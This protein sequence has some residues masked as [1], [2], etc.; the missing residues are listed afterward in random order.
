MGLSIEHHPSWWQDRHHH[1]TFTKKLLILILFFVF[2]S[3]SSFWMGTASCAYL[4]FKCLCLAIPFF[5]HMPACLY[6]TMNIVRQAGRHPSSFSPL[7][8][9]IYL[10][11]SAVLLGEALALQPVWLSTKAVVSPMFIFWLGKAHS[12]QGHAPSLAVY[13]V[14]K[15]FYLFGS[16]R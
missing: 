8:N 9:S 14:S 7:F 16:S 10:I 2:I 4:L 5:R 1:L 12:A 6:W 13:W 11:C 3:S 15:F